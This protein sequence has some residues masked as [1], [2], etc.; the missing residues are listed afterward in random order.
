M[1]TTIDRKHLTRPAAIKAMTAYLETI[2]TS[3]N[4]DSQLTYLH[5]KRAVIGL[6]NETTTNAAIYAVYDWLMDEPVSIIGTHPIGEFCFRCQTPV[7]HTSDWTL[8]PWNDGEKLCAA[9]NDA[10]HEIDEYDAV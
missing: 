3:E 9:C 2:R 5:G 4:P 6:L 1:T 8:W 10:R 7:A